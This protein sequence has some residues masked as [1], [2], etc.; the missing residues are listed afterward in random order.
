MNNFERECPYCGGSAF[1]ELM[2]NGV[3]MQQCQPFICDWCGSQE[4]G[5]HQEN[6]SANIHEKKTGWWMHPD[7]FELKDE[8]FCN[9]RKMRIKTLKSKYDYENRGRLQRIE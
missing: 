4:I 9:L 2:D 8:D 6:S 5:A 7:L 3:G 1:C